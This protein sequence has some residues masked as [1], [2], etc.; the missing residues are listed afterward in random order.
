MPRGL[1]IFVMMLLL[2]SASAHRRATRECSLVLWRCRALHA[3]PYR[4]HRHDGSGDDGAPGGTPRAVQVY[5]RRRRTRIR[6]VRTVR[7]ADVNGCSPPRCRPLRRTSDEVVVLIGVGGGVDRVEP[8]GESVDTA[9][10]RRAASWAVV[11]RGRAGP[12]RVAGYP[13]SI[14]GPR[15]P[16]GIAGPQSVRD[17][18]PDRFTQ[19]VRRPRAESTARPPRHGWREMPCWIS[20]RRAR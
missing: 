15:S 19:G 1:C 12:R 20:S 7:S 14:A 6:W 13:A 16:A 17:E 4:R 3:R 9:A 5:L 8:L 11:A 2:L 10:P 18:P